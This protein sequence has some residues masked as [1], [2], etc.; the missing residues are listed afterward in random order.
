MR[1][2]IY[3]YLPDDIIDDDEV[4]PKW[5]DY[6]VAC[7]PRLHPYHH[8]M[9]GELVLT[10]YYGERLENSFGDLVVR[11]ASE[12]ERD[13]DNYARRRIMT[14]TWFLDD[15][16]PHAEQKVR[17]KFYITDKE[18]VNELKRRRENIV[19]WLNGA[20]AGT[21]LEQPQRELLQR[22]TIPV[23]DYVSTGSNLLRQA[24]ADAPEAWLD[25]KLPQDDRY[26]FRQFLPVELAKGMVTG[27]V[28]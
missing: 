4:V 22:L 24:I 15:D 20:L 21:P 3:D 2:K 14:I 17:E 19:D 28:R 27:D 25:A 23:V 12:Y 16:N 10:Q 8:F 6:R 1:L 5:L 26:T 18:R 9:F 11:E 7:D 13:D